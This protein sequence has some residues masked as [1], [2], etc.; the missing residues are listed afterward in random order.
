[1]LK[2]SFGVSTWSGIKVYVTTWD[3]DGIKGTFRPLSPA[4]GQWEMGGGQATDPKIMDD[5][6]PISIP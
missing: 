1:Y 3:F 5:H 4:G 2:K 6:P